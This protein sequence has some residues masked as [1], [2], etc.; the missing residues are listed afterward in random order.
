MAEIGA[1]AVD[2]PSC[3]AAH[4]LSVEVRLRAGW[5][6][7]QLCRA[8]DGAVADP[9]TRREGHFQLR[10]ICKSEETVQ[11]YLTRADRYVPMQR[12]LEVVTED[13]QE[14][15]SL[16][17]YIDRTRCVVLEYSDGRGSK[18]ISAGSDMHDAYAQMDSLQGTISD[19]RWYA[20]DGSLA[21]APAAPEV[22]VADA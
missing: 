18:P 14:Q 1:A 20:L 11:A 6:R 12:H 22:E 9:W 5:T 16:S 17:T 21:A 10:Q 7:E 3:R 2:L 13:E 15:C 4:E 19:G 8:I